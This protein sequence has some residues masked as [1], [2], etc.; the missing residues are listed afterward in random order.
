MSRAEG[1]LLSGRSLGR[2]TGGSVLAASGVEPGV[3]DGVVEV[4]EDVV[5]AGEV[6]E[7][8]DGPEEPLVLGSRAL[9]QHGDVAVLEV[10]DD[11]AERLGAGGV[12]DLQVG[13]PQDH[14]PDVGDLGQVGEEALGGAE[15][16]RAV[17][18]VGDD[19]LAE[20]VVLLVGVD[21]GGRP[22]SR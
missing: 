12:E 6:V 22:A 10:G 15:E 7:R 19:V 1:P 16:Q 21:L 2:R 20:Q 11:L 4:G 9:E 5:L 13:Q 17:D 3:G 18:A 14:D 8:A